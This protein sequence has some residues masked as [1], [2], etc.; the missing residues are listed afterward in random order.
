MLLRKEWISSLTLGSAYIFSAQYFSTLMKM[1]RKSGT[2]FKAQHWCISPLNDLSLKKTLILFRSKCALIGRLICG[3]LLVFFRGMFLD[4]ILPSR[5]DNGIRPAIGQRTR[6][7]KGD[8]AQARKLYRC[9]GIAPYNTGRNR[10]RGRSS[11]WISHDLLNC[12]LISFHA[13]KWC[14]QFKVSHHKMK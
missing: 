13:G 9:P 1:F 7:S 11:R 5:D 8:I 10:A 14:V 6:L 4:T 3:L 12:L 2:L